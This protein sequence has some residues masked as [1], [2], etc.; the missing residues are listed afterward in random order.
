MISAGLKRRLMTFNRK[1]H[2]WNIQEK[3]RKRE[4][5]GKICAAYGGS[6]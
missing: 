2:V 3:D 6:L 1:E 4:A 5:A